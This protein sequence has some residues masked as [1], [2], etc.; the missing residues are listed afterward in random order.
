MAANPLDLSRNAFGWQNEI[1]APVV[2]GTAGHAVV[3]GRGRLLGEGDAALRFDVFEAQ[4]AVCPGAGKTIPMAV[5]PWLSA[6]E[7]MKKLT[8][9]GWLG[10]LLRGVRVNVLSEIEMKAFGGIT[11]TQSGFI[12]TPDLTSSTGIAV[13][14]AMISVNML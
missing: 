9:R 4:C 3:P 11:Y 10:P 14:F 5:A 7:R 2:N 8:A 1:H 12:G 13:D 6:S